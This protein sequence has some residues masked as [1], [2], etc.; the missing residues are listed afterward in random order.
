MPGSSEVYG[1]HLGM[2]LF[3]GTI[4]AVKIWEWLLD[5]WKICGPLLHDSTDFTAIRDVF[6]TCH[7]QVS[8]ATV[9]ILSSKLYTAMRG[10][11]RNSATHYL[12]LRGTSSPAL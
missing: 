2:Y 5:F 6:V 11:D 9:A 8:E 7:L 1:L 12:L 3:L 4:L 10:G